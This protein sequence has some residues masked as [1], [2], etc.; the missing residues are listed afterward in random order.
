MT[1]QWFGNTLNEEKL[2]CF[3]ADS[4]SEV[5][6][7]ARRCE[8]SS[9]IYDFTPFREKPLFQI[10][11]TCYPVDVGFL[12]D[13]I[14]TGP[15]WHVQRGLRGK[16]A[17]RCLA[18]WARIF[19]GYVKWLLQ[20]SVDNQKNR[21]VANPLFCAKKNEKREISDGVVQ[22]GSFA[23]LIECK[24]GFF[25]REAKYGGDPEILRKAITEK[26]IRTD[27]REKKGIE[28]LASS[29]NL[30]FARTTDEKA[31]DLAI[32]A[33][34]WVYPVLIVREPLVDAPGINRLLNR[35]F[36][37]LKE[38]RKLRVKVESLFCLSAADL[39]GISP[40]L[41]GT[42]LTDIL[43]ARK[44]GDRN[45]FMPFA[46]APN[47]IIEAKTEQGNGCI[48]QKFSEIMKEVAKQLFPD[49]AGE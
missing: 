42:R 7:L 37:K 6:E 45:L 43:D 36:A 34:Q 21:F 25:D 18:F 16:E 3:L 8:T 41:M 44:A 32:G 10:G 35:E 28:Q 20:D 17:K 26:L 9:S 49:E 46:L 14:E 13:K 4:S 27:E 22:C 5:P 39:E 24:G 40:L 23:V 12:A 33:A 30:L 11:D 29:I 19:E 1:R 48:A 31:E 38:R 15:F 2:S 47:E